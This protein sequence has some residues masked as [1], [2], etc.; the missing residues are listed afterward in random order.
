M[1]IARVGSPSGHSSGCFAFCSG[2]HQ[3][4]QTHPLSTMCSWTVFSSLSGNKVLISSRFGTSFPGTLECK[5][6]CVKTESVALSDSEAH[7]WLSRRCLTQIL[8]CPCVVPY[9]EQCGSSLSEGWSPALTHPA[10]APGTCRCHG[11][12]AQ[13]MRV[14]IVSGMLVRK[15][16]LQ[17][18]MAPASPGWSPSSLISL[19]PALHHRF[20]SITPN[21]WSS[22]DGS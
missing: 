9:W 10:A 18:W 4:L 3:A 17:R 8:V 13:R 1:A 15:Q 20:Y 19:E 6:H 16:R 2:D 14:G 12:S 11:V 7:R 5:G 21:C 22:P